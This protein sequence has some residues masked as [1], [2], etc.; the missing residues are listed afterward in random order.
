MSGGGDQRLRALQR[1]WEETGQGEDEAAWLRE[2]LRRGAL[3][4]ERLEVCA[5]LG[6]RP[7]RLACDAEGLDPP[8]QVDLNVMHLPER[9]RAYW[10]AIVLER[11]NDPMSALGNGLESAMHPKWARGLA[12]F[13]LEP[14]LR[15]ALAWKGYL[16]LWLGSL[17]AT[18]ST[19]WITHFLQGTLEPGREPLPT[20]LGRGQSSA[21]RWFLALNHLREEPLPEDLSDRLA[22][23]LQTN[24][25]CFVDER[26]RGPEPRG[27]PALARAWVVPWALGLPDPLDAV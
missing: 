22:S 27:V 17:G 14:V 6:Y 19:V 2:R 23:L 24:A 10:K 9:E 11:L 15:G 1:R 7:A 13:G 20:A 5:M 3:A 8:T 18:V 12:Q 16:E 25:L 26:S 21:E 4:P